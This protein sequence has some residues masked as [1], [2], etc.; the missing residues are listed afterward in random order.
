[1]GPGGVSVGSPPLDQSKVNQTLT[2]AY[3]RERAKNLTARG[4]T[5]TASDNALLSEAYIALFSTSFLRPDKSAER[6]QK[7][8]QIE[9]IVLGPDAALDQIESV[10][11]VLDPSYPRGEYVIGVDKRREKFKFKELANGYSIVRAELRFKGQQEPLHLNRF[12][13]LT[14]DGPRI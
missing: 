10:R 2:D 9:V 7:M 3:E 11:Y 13:N 1:M 14:D 8:W 12:I 6:G 5:A 4:S